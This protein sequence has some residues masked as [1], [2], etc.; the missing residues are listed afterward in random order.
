MNRTSISVNTETAEAFRELRDRTDA[1]GSDDMVRR[2]MLRYER[3]PP[4][5]QGLRL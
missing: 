1:F 4:A 5:E 3:G 2:L